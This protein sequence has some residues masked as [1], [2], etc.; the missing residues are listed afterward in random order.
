MLS[1]S[2]SGGTTLAVA[3][4]V[5]AHLSVSGGSRPAESL[6]DGFSCERRERD[7]PESTRDDPGYFEIRARR[8]ACQ[9]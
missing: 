6:S 2:L 3:E 1:P 8:S 7:P 4:V 5:F 9:A